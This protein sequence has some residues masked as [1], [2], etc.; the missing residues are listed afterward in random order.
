M[1]IGLVIF[2]VMLAGVLRGIT[3]FGGAML[4]TPLLS[5]V[6]GGVP[7]IIIVL[8][9]ET[10]AALIMVPAIYGDVRLGRLILLT[11]PACL[12]VPIG[13]ALLTSLDPSSSRRL[14]G[15]AVVVFSL[16]LMSGIRYSRH[17][18][19]SLTAAVGALSGVLLGATSIGA[20]PVILFLLSGPDPAKTTRAILTV[21]I[22]ITS[23]V[24]VVATLHNA[25]RSA[26]PASWV[27]LLCVIY[28]GSIF[29]GMKLFHKLNDFGARLIALTLMLIF[30][31]ITVVI[32]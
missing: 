19:P 20:P 25:E 5:V 14:I 21:F 12:T 2:T 7:A 8:A 28:L 22:S 17:P 30:G 24:G 23:L 29:V 1:T 31:V 27:C 15:G 13:S 32:G 26:P 16:A 3:G 6:L 18:T 10:A 11:A 4:M 9:I